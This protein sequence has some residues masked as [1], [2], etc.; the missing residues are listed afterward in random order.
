MWALYCV[1]CWAG[2]RECIV[3]GT[4]S[5]YFVGQVFMSALCMGA[6]TVYFVGQVFVSV[7][8][9]GALTVCFVWQ[10]FVSASCVGPWRHLSVKTATYNTDK[11]STPQHSVPSAA[12]WY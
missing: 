2:I 1:F 4:L 9:M 10:V 7:L 3:H 6:F 5:V 8:C 11:D 12:K